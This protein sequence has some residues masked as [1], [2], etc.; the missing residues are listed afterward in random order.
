M[1]IHKII[2]RI[3]NGHVRILLPENREIFKVEKNEDKLTWWVLY[4]DGEKKIEQE[5]L[6]LKEDEN[7]PYGFYDVGLVAEVASGEFLLWV[8]ED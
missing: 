5:Y 1:R 2:T 4:E 6:I 3:F 7:I 8:E